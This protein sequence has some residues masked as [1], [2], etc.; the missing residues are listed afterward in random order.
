[1]V[2]TFRNWLRGHV[3][4]LSWLA[5]TLLLVLITSSFVDSLQKWSARTV[6]DHDAKAFYLPHAKRLINEGL[7]FLLTEAA[8]Q[9]PPLS[10]IFPALFGAELGRQKQIAIGLSALVIFLLFRAGWVMH[11]RLA[12][13]AAA[14]LFASSRLFKAF[15]PTAGV[16]PLFIFLSAFWIWG[17]AEGWA[18]SRNWAFVA[19]GIAFGLAALTRA[20]IVYFFPLMVVVSWWLME[21]SQTNREQW[22]G[23]LIAHL[24]GFAI[25]LPVLIKNLWLFSL[26]AVSTGAGIALFFG[27]SP[28]VWGFDQ[29]YYTV[30]LDITAIIPHGASHLDVT[31]DRRL[32]AV[33]K[34]MLLTQDIGLTLQM[35]LLKLQAFLFVSDREWFGLV[36][37]FRNHR[38]LLFALCWPILA[39]IRSFPVAGIVG[40]LLTYQIIVHIPV[41]Y[42]MRYSVV[43][44]DLGLVFIAGLGLAELLLGRKWLASVLTLAVAGLLSLLMSRS[45]NLPPQPDLNLDAVQSRTVVD[46]VPTQFRIAE[47]SSVRQPMPGVFDVDKTGDADIDFDFTG[48]PDLMR[49]TSHVVAFDVTVTHAT[50]V[51]PCKPRVTYYYRKLRQQE[52]T[53]ERA[54]Y[55]KWHQDPGRHRYFIGGFMNLELY[56]PGTL[57]IRAS[58]EAGTRIQIG[59]IK[60]VEPNTGVEYRDGYLKSKGWSGWPAGF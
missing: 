55:A 11:S 49:L 16:E 6:F 47:S 43:A 34:H 24:I 28:L 3:G 41:L 2:A 46:W 31:S 38:I 13:L 20:T 52:F 19:A 21:R 5:I 54:V 10:Y 40:G 25:V 44:L 42:A 56:E 33:A 51:K 15:L 36:S 8:A 59:G 53:L 32:M 4:V 14:A 17:L 7:P 50:V 22:R 58:C 23:V 18:R 26:P 27:S 1:M 9:V 35:C 29:N 37:E 57:R 45:D 39:K 12:G 60:I 48:V 30:G